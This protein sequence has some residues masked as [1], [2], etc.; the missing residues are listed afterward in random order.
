[1]PSCQAKSVSTARVA[2]RGVIPA[3]RII[4]TIW[5]N[6]RKALSGRD[7]EV[8]RSLTGLTGTQSTACFLWERRCVG[9]AVENMYEE[10]FPGWDHENGLSTPLCE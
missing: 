9:E 7:V 2:F 3:F 10:T 8:S 6:G 4:V 1:M 5:A